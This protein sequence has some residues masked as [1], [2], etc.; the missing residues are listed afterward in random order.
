LT[1]RRPKLS[2]DD[3][4]SS[5]AET[6]ITVPSCAVHRGEQVMNMMRHFPVVFLL[7]SVAVLPACS[8]GGGNGGGQAAYTLAQPAGVSPATIGQVQTRLQ[9]EGDYSGQIDGIWGPST[10]AGVRAYQQHH[11]L[12]VNGQLDS[13]T[14]TAMNA[15]AAPAPMAATSP[16]PSAPMP[17]APMPPAASAPTQPMAAPPMATQSDTSTQPMAPK[18]P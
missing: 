2:Y 3:A 10:E 8:M 16:A 6:I 1:G 12:A 15:S 13:A 7:S 9:Q 17:S 11:S 4:A 18:T 14:M 5:I